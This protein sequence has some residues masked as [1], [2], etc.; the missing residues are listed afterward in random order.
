MRERRLQMEYDSQRLQKVSSIFNNPYAYKCKQQVRSTKTRSYK[1]N[2]AISPWKHKQTQV[3]FMKCD[4]LTSF[5]KPG[6][7]KEQRNVS[8]MWRHLMHFPSTTFATGYRCFYFWL[9]VNDIL[10]IQPR[11]P[12]LPR[13][14]TARQA[15]GATVMSWPKA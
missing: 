11:L 14:I 2:G 5:L 15:L 3:H 12:R 7:R 9:K 13:L 4:S 1:I 8:M 10:R 6:V